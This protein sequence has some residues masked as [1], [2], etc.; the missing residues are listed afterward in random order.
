MINKEVIELLVSAAVEVADEW[1]INYRAMGTTDQ[2][3][4]AEELKEKMY[5]ALSDKSGTQIS[6]P[7]RWARV[8]SVLPQI[9]PM[10]LR[11]VP[12]ISDS[13]IDRVR[14]RIAEYF[15]NRDIDEYFGLPYTSSG[16]YAALWNT[17]ARDAEYEGHWVRG[18]SIS[19][20]GNVIMLTQDTD[21]KE[22]W[23]ILA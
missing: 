9:E 1:D 4:Y 20:A 12:E 22:Y 19:R 17:N 6:V 3:F 2:F 13:E 21:E 11:L 5:K 23:Y 10:D 15:P 8:N 7:Q 16:M 14:R 18:F